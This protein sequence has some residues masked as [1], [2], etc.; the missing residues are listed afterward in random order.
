MVKTFRQFEEDIVRCN[1]CG[2]CE[3]VCP[4]YKATGEEFSLARGRN[5]LMRQSMEG[6]FDLTKEPEINHH[7]YSCL[8]CGACVVTCPSS[9]ITDTLVKAARAE[10]TR[11]NG[12]PFPIRMALHG[13]LARQRRLTLGA[14]ALRFYQRSGARWLARHT[15]FL[16]LLGSLGKAEGLL[17]DIPAR[18]LRER[19]PE[20]L[21]KP[22]KPR[23]KVAYFAGCMMN[24]FF[25]QVAE[26]SLRVFQENDIEVVVPT[27]NC[28]GI[29]HEAYGE[30]EMQIK[31]AKENLD[32]FKRFNVE[33]VVTDCASCAHGLHYYAELLK[34]DPQYGPLAQQ[35]AA[36]V[37]EASQ[38][39]AEV[40]FK[41]EMGPV[42][43][44]VTYHDP[45]HAVRGLKVKDEP[46][47]ILKS[48]PGVKFVE[49]NES[50]WCC[51]GAGSYNVTHYDLSQRILA[52]KMANFKKTGAQYLATSCPA[53]LMQLAHG[54]DVHQLP[55]RAIHVMQL[56]DQAYQNRAVKS[57]AKAV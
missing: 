8:L 2:F 35:F 55:G 16:G 53:C 21:K 15:G 5:R 30:T 34:D 20:I 41:K 12:N 23:H 3:E 19:L 18:T 39:L 10:I 26:A 11:A 32:S 7:I 40:G 46:R 27:S 31:L 6:H 17:P 52:R 57:G 48:I 44:T 47:Q 54:L 38:Y 33:A 28:C 50:D 4:T 42:N 25:P 45:C 9:V 51:G 13:V 22:L 14:K 56:L 43:A 29:P 37:K 1:R 36:K 49:M 24:N